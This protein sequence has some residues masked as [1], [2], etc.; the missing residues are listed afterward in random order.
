LDVEATAAA[1]DEDLEAEGERR[2]LVEHSASEVDDAI[3]FSG[4]S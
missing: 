1:G 3:E 2:A 4:R